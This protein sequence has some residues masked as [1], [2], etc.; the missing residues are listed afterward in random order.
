TP[1]TAAKLAQMLGGKVVTTNAIT[2]YGPFTQNQPN[3]M[4][5]LPNGKVLNAGIIADIYNHGYSQQQ[6]NMM[7][8]AEVNDTTT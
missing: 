1:A 3:Q 5:Q 8:S 4:V 6:I 2:P 7:V